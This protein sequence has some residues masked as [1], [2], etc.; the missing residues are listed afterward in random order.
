ME[1]TITD[2]AREWIRSKGGG[3]VVDLIACST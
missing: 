1:V 2:Q 3:A